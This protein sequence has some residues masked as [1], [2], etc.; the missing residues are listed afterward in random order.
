MRRPALLVYGRVMPR[1]LPALSLLFR[2]WRLGGSFA[3]LLLVTTTVPCA[4]SLDAHLTPRELGWTTRLGTRLPL[5]AVMRDENGA[6]EPLGTFFAGRPVVLVF[7]DRNCMEGCSI[8]RANLAAALASPS[9]AHSPA[10]DVLYVSLDPSDTA[11]ELQPLEQSLLTHLRSSPRVADLH[12][13]TSDAATLARITTATGLL[14]R[15]AAI[16]PHSPHAHGFLV[17]SAAGRITQLFPNLSLESADLDAALG[18]A[19]P[20]ERGL[21]RVSAF[22]RFV[23]LALTGRLGTPTRLG[24]ETLLV[25]A[26]LSACGGLHWLWNSL[27][28]PHGLSPRARLLVVRFPRLHPHA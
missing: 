3:V 19:A 27:P 5:N 28:P 2:R 6:T 26:L 8:V 4:Q 1:Q 7:G 23:R 11:K 21:A 15:S 9:T 17:L 24:L 22:P 13:L 10:C 14:A 16:P 12:V 25:L 18:D 20:V